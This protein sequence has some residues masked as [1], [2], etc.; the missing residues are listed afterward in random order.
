MKTLL[1][2]Y[3]LLE[4]AVALALVLAI[5]IALS[6]HD[7]DAQSGGSHPMTGYAWS[8]TIG[9]IDLNCDNSSTCATNDFGLSI[10]ADGTITGFA[11]SEHIGWVSAETSDLSG[12]PSGTCTA[13]YSGGAL[14]G[15]LKA[16]AADGNGWDGWIS[17]SGSGYGPTFSGG[18]FSGYAWGSDVVG[19]VDF[20]NAHPN[21]TPI[22]SCS[23]DTIQFTDS[24]CVV[25]NVET[26]VSPAFCSSGSSVCLSPP[27]SFSSFTG[28]DGFAAS[29]HLEASPQ[30]VPSLSTTQ[31]YWDL[32]NVES[33]TVTGTNGDSWTG[34]SSGSAGQTSSPIVAQT[35]YTL[36]CDA[37]DGS[38]VQETVIVLLIPIFNEF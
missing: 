8:D 29:G 30:I 6:A 38:T 27:P 16:L 24:S 5:G 35:V 15:W 2:K 17:L 31:V 20:S 10:A 22:Y 1:E 14:S 33:C 21:C 13:T 23:G 36:D 12:C 4:I 28:D 37:L 26:C 19:W 32:E 11:W 25:S 3:P 7:V 18:A 9:W 34:A